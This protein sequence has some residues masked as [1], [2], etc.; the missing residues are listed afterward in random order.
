[1]KAWDIVGYT[2][3]ADLWCPACATAT[4][5]PDGA[6]EVPE[7]AE[8]GEGNL[9]HPIFASDELEPGDRCGAC[10]EYLAGAE[11]DEPDEPEAP[12]EWPCCPHCL[13]NH[14]AHRTPHHYPCRSCHPHLEGL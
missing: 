7:D 13:P 8:D 9:V 2:A 11:P 14:P 10:H 3:D 6:A 12:D 1:M 5:A 4:Y